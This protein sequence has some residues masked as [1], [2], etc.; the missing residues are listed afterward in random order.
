M[1]PRKPVKFQSDMIITR[2]NLPASRL[3][4]LGSKTSVH[5]INRGPEAIPSLDCE[6]NGVGC[7]VFHLVIPG[8][9]D[10]SV[11]T[12]P[13][14]FSRIVTNK[15]S[16]G[17]SLTGFVHLYFHLSMKLSIKLS[18]NSSGEAVGVK[19]F[20][21]RSHGN[22]CL[23]MNALNEWMYWPYSSVKERTLRIIGWFW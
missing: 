9:V 8:R 7:T 15:C 5:L 22:N 14:H 1:L 13:W 21:I 10:Q 18:W 19:W 23:I 4:E 12:H 2:P 6:R 11:H 20:W 3:C 16:E 17:D